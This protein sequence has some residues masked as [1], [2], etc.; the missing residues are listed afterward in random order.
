MVASMIYETSDSMVDN[1][2]L[3]C[4]IMIIVVPIILVLA[5]LITEARI[6]YMKLKRE[7]TEDIKDKYG[8]ERTDLD[9]ECLGYFKDYIKYL[10]HNDDTGMK[11]IL[12]VKYYD[13]YMS[14]YDDIA[15]KK[16]TDKY[17]LLEYSL[18]DIEDKNGVLFISYDIK[19]FHGLFFF[20][21]ISLKN[22][23]MIYYRI[24]YSYTPI[25]NE[26]NCTSCGS[27]LKNAYRCPSCYRKLQYNEH[28]LK[29]EQIDY[30]KEIDRWC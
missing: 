16:L 3:V 5:S 28:I 12:S 10:Y 26:K 18:V 23:K 30:V 8:L 25:I 13:T 22:R 1:I 11:R 4:S 24:T 20:N 7:V 17:T 21:R 19:A 15:K 27:V 6:H 14:K 9:K 29:I 2:T